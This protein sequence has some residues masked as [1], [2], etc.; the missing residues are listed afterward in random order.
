MS[1]SFFTVT[2]KSW[3]CPIEGTFQLRGGGLT[4]YSVGAAPKEDHFSSMDE[5]FVSQGDLY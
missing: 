2:Q 1:D 3:H 5:L 4:Q